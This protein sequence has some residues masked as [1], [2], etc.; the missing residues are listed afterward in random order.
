MSP[1]LRRP[2]FILII[3]AVW[4]LSLACSLLPKRLT[5]PNTYQVPASESTSTLF[6]DFEEDLQ[7]DIQRERKTYTSG[8]WYAARGDYLQAG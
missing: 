8:T 5:Q 1:S 4:L 7:D 6:D 2:S 3:L